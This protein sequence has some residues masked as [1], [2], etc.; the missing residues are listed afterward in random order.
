MKILH[1]VHQ[2][3]PYHHHGAEISTY[4]LAVMQ[5]NL[6]HEVAVV[7]GENG[8]FGEELV[9]ERD[10]YRELTVHRIYF[11]PRSPNGWLK[12]LGFE[13][14]WRRLLELEQPDVVHVQHLL[15]LS[16]SL[17][18]VT[19]E[20][21][22]P[23]VFT[24]RDFAPLCARVNLVRGDGSLCRTT[25]LEKDCLRCLNQSPPLPK[26]DLLPAGADLLRQ[27]VTN[28]RAWKLLQQWVFAKLRTRVVYPP[29][30]LD[31][32]Q[33][34]R[35]RNETVLSRL[36]QFDRITAISEDTAHRFEVLARKEV[37]V[38]VMMQAPDTSRCVWRQRAL[39]DGPLRI[40]YIG[41]MTRVKGV[42]V[43]LNAFRRLPRN[44]AELQLFGG[45]TRTSLRELAYWRELRR[46]G[47]WTGVHF[48]PDPFDPAE[49]A[50]VLDR[51]DLLVI[52]SIWFEAYGR[53]VAEAL[54]SGIPVVCSDEGGP[55][56]IITEGVNGLTFKLGDDE[57]LASVLKRF[58]AEPNL[59]EHLSEQ[60]RPPKTTDRYAKEVLALYDEIRT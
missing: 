10:Q 56:S 32:K 5:Q 39:G 14:L 59:L 47:E 44:Q 20:L 18:E 43:L 51:F 1:V 37:E 12:H 11:N 60:A 24:L 19:R 46:L 13:R 36:K 26:Q 45:P 33:D 22:I 35:R 25:D 48:H 53:V 57:A 28:P 42:H 29:V 41:K 17:V 15:K 23:M 8:H 16:W 27:N 9:L 55:A 6:G 4:E 34:M 40:G 3:L 50:S 2:F 49:I 31:T 21:G 38:Q 52:P 54:A 58:L 30:R 7:T